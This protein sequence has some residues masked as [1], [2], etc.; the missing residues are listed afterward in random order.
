MFPSTVTEKLNDTVLNQALGL[1]SEE[2]QE[3]VISYAEKANEIWVVQGA[4]GFIM[5]EDKDSV[6]LPLFPHHDLASRFVDE[7]GITGKCVSIP[8]DEFTATW[9]P[10]LETNGV[11]LVMFPTKSDAENLV[12]TA[13]DLAAEFK[14]E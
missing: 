4:E 14:G 5:L 11:E 2:R 9:L 1:S 6:R 13:N 8:L 12:M 3:L 10:G 7:N